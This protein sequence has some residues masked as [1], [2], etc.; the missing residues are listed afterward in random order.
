[1]KSLS[2]L[3]LLF[4]ILFSCNHEKNSSQDE[5]IEERSE[6]ELLID[7]VQENNFLENYT[8]VSFLRKSPA[9]IGCIFENEFH[10]RDSI[11]NCS[12]KNYIN[13]GDPCNNTDA[14]YEGI[15]I[16]DSVAVKI[17]PKIA[18]FELHF[19]NGE[20]QEMT[21][22]FKDSIDKSALA[23]IF[24]L[25]T[26]TGYPENVISINYGE[27]I[28]SADKPQNEDYTKWLTITGFDHQ[29]SGD[30]DCD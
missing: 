18:K 27:N 9:E 10:Y 15:R 4:L 24:E 14:Y 1:M 12:N 5:T 23:K 6:N 28:V 22:T 19:E 30:V 8:L 16:P 25:P 29:G 21:V 7:S 2:T 3:P 26:E 20:L 17:H 11:F 13:E